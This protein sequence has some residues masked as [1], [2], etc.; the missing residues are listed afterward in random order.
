MIRSSLSSGSFQRLTPQSQSTT[1]DKETPQFI[2]S[3]EGELFNSEQEGPDWGIPELD[4]LMLKAEEQMVNDSFAQTKVIT[5]AKPITSILVKPLGSQVQTQAPA[6]ARPQTP[7]QAHPQARAQAQ[8]SRL[9]QTH[10]HVPQPQ[11]FVC[12]LVRQA[13]L[14]SLHDKDSPS[15]D[16][17]T[18]KTSLIAKQ[19]RCLTGS[20]LSVLWR[21]QTLRIRIR[22]WGCR[23]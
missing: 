2:D 23:I 18:S 21:D 17:P 4:Q 16:F 9:A 6:P 19:A 12:L 8:P 7:A 22:F 20:R 15:L 3:S 10:L 14:D 1:V 5:K 11:A 13:P